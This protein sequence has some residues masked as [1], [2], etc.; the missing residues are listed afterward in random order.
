M[1]PYAGEGRC[2]LMRAE[3]PLLTA[4]MAPCSSD[5]FLDQ[6]WPSR[7]FVAHGPRA[8][9]PAM[10]LE[11]VLEGATPLAQSY[12]GRLRFTHGG[13]ERMLPVGDA[14]PPSLLDMGLTVQFVDVERYLQRAPAFVRQLELELGLHEGA[15]S[16]SAFASAGDG[17]LSC[18]FDTSEL[19]SVQLEGTKRFHFAPMMEIQNPL[20]VRSPPAL[21]RLTSSI[22]S[23]FA[24]FPVPPQR[25]PRLH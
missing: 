17:G 16:M 13:S 8:R 3:C 11:P 4:L 24:V 14:S 22:P 19:I 23:A 1:A 20:G 25:A 7:A 12:S 2:N 15:V 9:L 10:L 6:Y 21:R 18:H 5:D